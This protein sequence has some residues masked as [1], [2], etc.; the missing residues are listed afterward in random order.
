MK[1]IID[2][3]HTATEKEI[4][5]YLKELVH[6]VINYGVNTAA[7]IIRLS[8]EKLDMQLYLVKGTAGF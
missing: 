8:E 7:V 1:I 6:E 5:Q 2:N 3:D 4:I